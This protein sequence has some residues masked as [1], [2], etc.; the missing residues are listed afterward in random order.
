METFKAILCIVGACV[1][2]YALGSI[3]FAVI[4]SKLFAKKDVRD[5]GSGNAGMTNVMRA[6]G[7]LPGILTFVCDVLK[8]AAACAAAKYL[9][10][11]YVFELGIHPWLN[12]VYGA[13]FCGLLCIIG[14]A[15]PIFF[16]FKGGKGIATSVGIFAVCCYPAIIAGLAVFILCVLIS[17][18]VSLSS[19]LAAIT[20]AIGVFFAHESV[21]PAYPTTPAFI[22]TA[23]IALF[24]IIK[25]KDNIIR[26]I[27]GEEKRL[28]VRKGE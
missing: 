21:N 9:F 5:F 15:F 27:N 25:H 28:V 24:V 10:F 22:L 11:P 4:F 16:G 14:H 6:V 8:G 20:V 7:V 19:I 3:S 12:P 1:F 26:L 23:L 2:S 17:K 18:I 13:Y